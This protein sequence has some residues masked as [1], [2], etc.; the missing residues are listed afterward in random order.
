MITVI[1]KSKRVRCYNLNVAIP[2]HGAKAGDVVLK[3]KKTK[4]DVK[5]DFKAKETERV[6]TM[7]PGEHRKNIPDAVASSPEVAAAVLK[8]E[9][10]IKSQKAQ[11]AHVGANEAKSEESKSKAAPR[12][13]V[14]E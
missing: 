1:S 12:K 8:G 7:L 3:D 6:L 11:S 4:K 13:S 10:L 14:N 9:L 2:V 5:Q